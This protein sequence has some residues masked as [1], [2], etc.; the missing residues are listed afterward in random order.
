MTT[1]VDWPLKKA[2]EK[3]ASISQD[4]YLTSQNSRNDSYNNFK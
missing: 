3:N 4:E 2:I 1:L